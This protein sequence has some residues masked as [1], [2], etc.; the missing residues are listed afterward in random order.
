MRFKGLQML[1]MNINDVCTDDVTNDVLYRVV[2]HNFSE[3]EYLYIR[4]TIQ[5]EGVDM[6]FV[7]NENYDE[8]ELTVEEES[9]VMRSYMMNTLVGVSE[10]E[11]MILS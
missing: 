7:N 5:L 2:G 3:Y 1:D 11:E 10:Y 8:L 9:Y 4:L 6:C